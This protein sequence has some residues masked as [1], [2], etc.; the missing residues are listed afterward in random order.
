[1]LTTVKSPNCMLTVLSPQLHIAVSEL[2]LPLTRGLP[3]APCSQTGE[4]KMT[5]GRQSPRPQFPILSIKIETAFSHS[6][7]C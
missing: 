1:M 3:D 2:P 4:G 7:F 5:K 6:L